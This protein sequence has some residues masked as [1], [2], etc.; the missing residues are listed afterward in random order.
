MTTKKEIQLRA[1]K[2]CRD[3]ITGIRGREI[4]ENH[5]VVLQLDEV[6]LKGLAIEALDNRRYS[7]EKLFDDM[8][9]SYTKGF[10]NSY[11][12]RKKNVETEIQELREYG[13][14]VGKYTLRYRNLVRRLEGNSQGGQK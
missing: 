7:L 4:A 2:R 6:A 12:L 11:A 9:E 14:H 1:L 8:K 10:L 3:I 13:I 5:R